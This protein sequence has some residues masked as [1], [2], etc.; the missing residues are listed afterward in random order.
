MT[1]SR[2]KPVPLKA[3]RTHCGTGFSRE[4]F[5]VIVPTLCVGMPART[6]R[7]LPGRLMSPDP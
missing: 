4:A 6:L 2:L 3:P 1:P 7:V 5:D